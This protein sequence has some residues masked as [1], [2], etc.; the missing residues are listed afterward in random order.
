MSPYS[1]LSG[2]QAYYHNGDWDLMRSLGLQTN[3]N[4]EMTNVGTV[5]LAYT[6][7]KVEVAALPAQFF[8]FT[9]VGP[10]GRT[11]VVRTGSGGFGDY[12]EPVKRFALTGCWSKQALRLMRQNMLVVEEEV[13]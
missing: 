9:V 8:R 12:W 13:A 5:E 4:R 2:G 6:T 10:T 7:V 1:Y 11:T 3:F